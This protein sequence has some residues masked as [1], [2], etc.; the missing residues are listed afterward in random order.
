[1]RYI[2]TDITSGATL[3][4][5]TMPCQGNEN[6]CPLRSQDLGM[7]KP[8]VEV[9]LQLPFGLKAT[10][11]DLRAVRLLELIEAHGSMTHAATALGI[12]YRTAW[13]LVDKLQQCGLHWSTQSVEGISTA[14]AS[15]HP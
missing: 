6:A 14:V 7:S 9:D 3:G 8:R 13:I 11:L 1:M 10:R 2:L 15:L 4:N 5:S 12:S